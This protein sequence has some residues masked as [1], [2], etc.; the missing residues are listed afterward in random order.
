MIPK[1]LRLLAQGP[2][3][4]GVLNAVE[5]AITGPTIQ[6]DRG[7]SLRGVT[8]MDEATGRCRIAFPSR[9]APGVRRLSLVFTGHLN[10]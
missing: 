8:A 7:E 9:L 5:V 4:T 1:A 10:D 2:P 3:P 6:N